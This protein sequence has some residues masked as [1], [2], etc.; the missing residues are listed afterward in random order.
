MVV[1]KELLKK[2]FSP[3][4]LVAFVMALM[5]A[6]SPMSVFSL[7]FIFTFVATFVIVFING[8]EFKTKTRKYI[9]II[10][11]SYMSNVLIVMYTNHTFAVFGIL[12]GVILTPVFAIIYSMS[13]FLFP[14]K[15][16]MN[17]IDCAFV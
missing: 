13:I 1:N 11:F 10:V 14:F 15:W 7:S 6:I 8:I 17:Y 16:L 2:R 3:I 4:Q 5:M 9:A 12:F